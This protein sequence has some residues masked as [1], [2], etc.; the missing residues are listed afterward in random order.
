M[1]KALEAE[2]ARIAKNDRSGLTVAWVLLLSLLLVSIGFNA[3]SATL[4][5]FNP[6]ALA[7]NTIPPIVLFGLSMA[8][9]RIVLDFTSKLGLSVS[10]AVSLMFSW[11]HIAQTTQH[12]AEPLMTSHVLK[13][14]YTITAW[15]FPLILDVPMV[16]AGKMIMTVRDR[17]SNPN[18]LALQAKINLGIATKPTKTTRSTQANTSKTNH[19]TQTNA[20]NR[21]SRQTSTKTT[22][23]IP[24]SA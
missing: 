11:V 18:V 5:G 16:L 23:V 22:K 4:H 21:T 17:R 8:L 3:L 24:Q 20:T 9:E 1:T 15:S 2:I 13:I 19:T 10:I 14:I 7:I 12:Y 6:I